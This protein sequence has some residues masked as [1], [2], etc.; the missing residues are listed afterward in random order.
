MLVRHSTCPNCE[1]SV[2]NEPSPKE[3]A[4]MAED[5][6]IRMIK[7]QKVSYWKQFEHGMLSREAVQSLSNLADT[8]SDIPE[9]IILASDLSPY[10]RVPTY[11]QKLVICST[12]SLFI[13]VQ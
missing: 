1:A 11:L 10:W 12:Y 3:F 9:R 2:P 5:G 8:V 6:R 7:A 13:L 4:E